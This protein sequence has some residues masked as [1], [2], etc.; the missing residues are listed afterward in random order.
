MQHPFSH[1]LIKVF[2]RSFFKVNMGLLVFLFVVLISYCFFINTA[3]DVKLLPK[4][5]ELYYQF[6]L[7][8]NFVTTPLMTGLFF[9]GWIL[10]TLKSWSFIA[11]QLTVPHH[12]FIYYGS[13]SYP[14][15][16]RFG[17][18]LV[19]QFVISLPFI[20]YGWLA[21]VI[22]I[23]LHHYLIVT[24]ILLFALILIALSA[25]VY[26]LMV[27]QLLVEKRRSWLFTLFGQ[28][29]KPWFSLYI[30]YIFDRLKLSFFVTKLFSFLIITGAFLFFRDVATDSRLAA[31]AM[32]GI[33][34][35]HIILIYRKHTFERNYLS[36]AHNLPYSVWRQFFNFAFTYLILLIPETVWLFSIKGIQAVVYL[37]LALSLMMVFHCL[38][39]TIRLA[40]RL[41]L[42]WVFSLFVGCFL[43]I[44]F[45]GQW[46][47][48]PVALLSSYTLFYFNHQKAGLIA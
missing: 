4:G 26:V 7:L 48:I 13:L 22:G 6:I 45:G 30:Y 23:A 33:V 27:N 28:W 47:L 37:L 20:C 40:M 31:L 36:I 17:S 1:L 42:P 2:A 14:V 24:V 21:A 44:L 12:Q 41:Y 43:F 15:S 25:A 18:W 39:Y 46:M 8:I 10:Y 9:L 3:G 5:A 29:Q 32:L 19:M 11:G 34:I 16:R 35:A 38:L